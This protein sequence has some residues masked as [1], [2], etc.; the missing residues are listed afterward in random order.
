VIDEQKDEP[1]LHR[2]QSDSGNPI[3]VLAGIVTE[4]PLLIE[5]FSRVWRKVWQAN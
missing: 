4:Q 5:S 2:V 3:E 1:R